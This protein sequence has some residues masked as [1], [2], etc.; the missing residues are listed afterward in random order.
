[1][2]YELI[3]IELVN[4]RA[5]FPKL[6]FAGL[7]KDAAVKAGFDLFRKECLKCHS[8]NLQGGDIGPE[9][10]IP[11]NITEYRDE[12]Y[13][14]SFIRNA[15]S[16]RAKSKMPPFLNLKDSEITQIIAYLRVMREHR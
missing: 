9:L 4:F 6:Y 7:E 13:L 1:M 11:K 3:A 15:S 12:T 8:L 14:K 2:P 16:Y 10:N 5:M